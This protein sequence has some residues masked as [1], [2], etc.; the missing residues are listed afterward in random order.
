[1]RFEDERGA[2]AAGDESAIARALRVVVVKPDDLLHRYLL[3]CR[4]GQADVAPPA[5][6]GV[7]VVFREI[8]ALVVLQEP[9][10]HEERGEDHLGHP[11][12][13]EEERAGGAVLHEKIV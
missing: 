4:V 7:A 12:V 2:G 1:V 11:E 3:G 5:H 13:L 6:A 10:A 9:E 8:E